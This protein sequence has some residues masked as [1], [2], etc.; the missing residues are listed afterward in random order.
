MPASPPII[1]SVPLTNRATIAIAIGQATQRPSAQVGRGTLNE[2]G[3][4]GS[5]IRRMITDTKI[6]T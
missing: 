3:A 5:L 1:Q 6:S 4:F 2:R